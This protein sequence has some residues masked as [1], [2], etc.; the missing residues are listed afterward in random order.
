MRLVILLASALLAT[1]CAAPA[2]E[3]PAPV[4]FACADGTTLRVTFA[5]ETARV[6]LP[7]GEELV[8]P[9]QPSG[10]GFRYAT[11]RH[12]LRGK[13]DEV[14]WTV[15]RRVPVSCRVRN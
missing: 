8:L 10:S 12:E 1:A 7:G 13:G 15:G 14:Q 11:P 3:A 5:G 9:R 2:P 4:T 6:T